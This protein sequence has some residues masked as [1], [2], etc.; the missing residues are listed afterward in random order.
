MKTIKLPKL[1]PDA[2]Y[3]V[4]IMRTGYVETAKAKRFQLAKQ[5]IEGVEVPKNTELW[6]PNHLCLTPDP[7]F[8]KVKIKGE[9][10]EGL[11]KMLYINKLR[12]ES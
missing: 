11:L 8:L 6:C 5:I 2:Y 7:Q 9:I 3:E 1:K 4:L 10:L 12:N